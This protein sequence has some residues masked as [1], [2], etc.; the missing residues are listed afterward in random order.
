VRIRTERTGVAAERAAR[1]L[2]FGERGLDDG[3]RGRERRVEPLRLLQ[4][5]E[6]PADDLDD[7]VF[8]RVERGLRAR[9]E[10]DEAFGVDEARALGEERFVLGE[11]EV[12]ARQLLGLE[13]QQL[14]PLVDGFLRRLRRRETLAR[15]DEALVANLHLLEQAAEAA[16]GVEQL[17][18]ALDA[19][20]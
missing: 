17:A 11:D 7:G 8:P 2:Q 14:A 1:I 18:V 13:L 12:G 9:R 16:G 20:E 10:A 5:R 15:G 4:R 3:A 19:A 6:R